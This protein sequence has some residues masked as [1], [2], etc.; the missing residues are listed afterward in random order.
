[1]TALTARSAVVQQV[2]GFPF[3][4][5]DFDPARLLTAVA[6]C[7]WTRAN[8]G[9]AAV[10]SRQGLAEVLQPERG[11]QIRR[12]DLELDLPFGQ[13]SADQLQQIEQTRTTLVQWLPDWAPRGAPISR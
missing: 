9:A 10:P 7:R 6:C 8:P 11:K 4:D 2:G 13:L 5:P 12:L 1:M 3:L